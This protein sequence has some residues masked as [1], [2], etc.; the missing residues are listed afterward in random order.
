LDSQ[1]VE[2]IG[3]SRLVEQLLLGGI[4]V[5]LPA[6]DRGIDLIAYLDLDEALAAFI[7]CPI[8]MKAATGR[9]FSIGAKYAKF[10]NLIH[11]Y[12]W[13]ISMEPEVYA[14]TQLE[15]V[16]V[17]E[18]MGYTRTRSWLDGGYYTTTKV[19]ETGALFDLLQRFRMTPELW[20]RKIGTAKPPR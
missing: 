1:A 18:E 5:A 16:E 6:R 8:Q 7:A 20:R 10:P 15:A 3:R 11:A 13:N 19:G 4:E 9:S 17:A 12:V 14:L 2:I